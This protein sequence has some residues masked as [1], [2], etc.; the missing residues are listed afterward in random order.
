M[1]LSSVAE[2]IHLVFNDQD[3]NPPLIEQPLDP[4]DPLL[5]QSTQLDFTGDSSASNSR[6]AV[7]VRSSGRRAT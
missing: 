4:V 2:R 3:A 1:R 6:F 7:G 5:E